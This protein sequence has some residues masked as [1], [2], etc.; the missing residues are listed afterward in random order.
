MGSIKWFSDKKAFGF[1]T[2]DDGRE[3]FVHISGFRDQES[4]PK[5]GA[6]V[7][8]RLYKSEKGLFARNVE[9]IG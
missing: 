2:M 3:C 6:K 1:I 4:M 9:V 5:P 8:F 7:T